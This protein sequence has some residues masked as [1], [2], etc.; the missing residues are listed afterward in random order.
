M[1]AAPWPPPPRKPRWEL[2]A[3]VVY[4]R[5]DRAVPSYRAVVYSPLPDSADLGVG[6]SPDEIAR[7]VSPGFWD[8]VGASRSVK[9]E[10]LA[11]FWENLGITVQAGGTESV[12][13]ARATRMAATARMRGVL[14]AVRCR[15][16]QGRPLHAALAE[17]PIQFC[18]AHCAL[19]EAATELPPDER[20]AVY[21]SVAG[22]LREKASRGRR[23]MAAMLDQVITGIMIAALVVVTL[24]YF[25]PNYAAMFRG[26]G[27]ELPW[28]YR[29]AGEFGGWIARHGLIAAATAVVV[30]LLG[31][32][33][34][35]SALARPAAQ[36]A[37]TRLPVFGP[38]ITHLALSRSLPLFAVLHK[39]G[40]HPEPAF[41]LAG[42]AAGN[43]RVEDF[44]LA[45]YQRCASGADLEKAFLAERLTLG[46]SEGRRIAGKIEAGGELGDLEG[47]LR[48]LAREFSET[49]NARVDALPK[50]VKPF[51]LAVMGLVIG[52]MAALVGL[53]SMLVLEKTFQ[54]QNQGPERH[55]P[56]ART[57]A[58]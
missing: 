30:A 29:L 16:N 10:E 50:V 53:P 26:L 57:A 32:R 28:P 46:L 19:A 27:L 17:F 24:V 43:A 18:R 33:A 1:S 14:G 41:R 58:P 25:V 7:R 56:D 8:G 23:F 54:Q 15:L 47:V 38:L 48:G 42:E 31:W 35:R 12:A 36:R 13:L 45:A 3:F 37:L 4:R 52:M 9:A 55:A 40:V 22:I 21:L 34:G 39:A 6:L 20:A 49:A 11:D 5:D 44:F 51:N 2:R